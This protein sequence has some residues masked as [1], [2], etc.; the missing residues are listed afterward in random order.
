MDLDEVTQVIKTADVLVIRFAILEKRLLM[1]ARSSEREGPMLKLVPKVSSAEERFRSLKELR[2]RF[3]VPDKI[4]SF[5]WPRHV[6]TFR[7][8][9]LW[10]CVVDRLSAS[11]HSGVEEQCKAVFE[12]LVVEEKKEVLTAIRGG[13]NYQSLWERGGEQQA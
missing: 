7:A 4:L 12:E 9:G 11:G 10:Q 8:A 1:D 6:E 3:P 5:T 13:E 2:P